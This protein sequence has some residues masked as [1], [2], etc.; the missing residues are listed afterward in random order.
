MPL[1]AEAF[2]LYNLNDYGVKLFTGFEE[3]H[4]YIAKLNVLEF[5]D[6][7]DEGSSKRSNKILFQTSSNNTNIL[8]QFP[9]TG[10]YKNELSIVNVAKSQITNSITLFDEEYNYLLILY[11]ETES[12]V[13]DLLQ[14]LIKLG[15]PTVQSETF[16]SFISNK[17]EELDERLFKETKGTQRFQKKINP[18]KK[19]FQVRSIEDHVHFL[20]DED[21]SLEE[22]YLRIIREFDNEFLN[23]Q[24]D[25][26]FDSSTTK[27][28]TF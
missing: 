17:I 18:K 24:N 16:D 4:L 5:T 3:D 12:K 21:P 26:T 15:I 9:F 28:P 23:P 10:I 25:N 2:Q 22:I 7:Y 19:T 6:E 13:E 8:K 1:T 20:E 11:L 14:Y 27:K